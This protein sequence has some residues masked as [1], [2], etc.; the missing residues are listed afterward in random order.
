MTL[1]YDMASALRGASRPREGFNPPFGV[2]KTSEPLSCPIQRTT[3]SW[4][5]FIMSTPRPRKRLPVNPS[6]EHLKKQAKR[7]AARQ[8]SMQLADAQHQLAREYGCKNWAELAQ[9]VETM[10]RG[11]TEKI[12]VKKGLE[13]LPDA[14]NR[15]DI[16]EVRR[17]LTDGQF[18]QYDLDLALAR[19][20]LN[21]RQRHEIAE[22]LIEHGADPDGQYGGNYGPI[23][24]ATAE[25]LDPDG[26][27]FLIDHGADVTF[28]PIDTKY[29]PASP[30]IGVL[31]TYARGHNDRKHRYIDIL[32]ARNAYIPP[33]VTP[34]VMA[35]HRG[36]VETLRQMLDA[37]PSLLRRRVHRI[38]GQMN[39]PLDT[40]TLLHAAVEFGELE[41]I[42][43]LISR[44]AD[45]NARAQVMDGVGGHTPIYHAIASTGQGNLYVL[46]HL[47][48]RYGLRIDMNVRATIRHVDDFYF[49]NVTPL[50]YSEA[51]SGEDTP[52]WRRSSKR[53]LEIMRSLALRQAVRRNDV[54]EVG[55]LLDRGAD[56][57]RRADGGKTTL[58]LSVETGSVAMIELLQSHGALAWID[59]ES[60]RK[61]IDYVRDNAQLDPAMRQRLTGLL[62]VP[63]SGD[64]NFRAAIVA[65]D[66][67]DL[68][69]LKELLR[70]S[71]NLATM[72][73]GD[74]GSFAGG[75]FANPAL[76]WYV[77]EN[78]IR[79]DTLPANICDIA[80]VIIDAGATRDDITYTM[81]LVASG[82]VPRKCGLQIPLIQTLVRRGGDPG[83]ALTAAVQEHEQQAIEAL[84][85]FG[86]KP[87]LAA[88]AGLGRLDEL[89]E[90]LTRNEQQASATSPASSHK[91]SIQSAMSLAAQY[92]QTEAMKML[93]DHGVDPNVPLGLGTTPLHQAAWHDR[94]EMVELLLSRGANPTA[95]DARFDATPA[96][97]A[98]HNAH[99]ELADLLTSAEL[100]HR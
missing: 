17:I 47:I 100:S 11:A 2:V 53:E 19:A 40:A 69:T 79:N 94:R 60:G 3:G 36:D 35:I 24:L 49:R 91:T 8:P 38:P 82:C 32:L 63:R 50:E 59:D 42:D 58:H 14:A 4:K 84:L 73:S 98:R 34:E 6:I 39:P 55:A 65:I 76:L 12:S 22:L 62:D 81:A 23:V 85:R 99:P 72:H 88:A 5:G 86:A 30:M 92:G 67:G 83:G 77:A 7:I 26:L 96:Q 43:L 61:P 75:Y 37:D 45:I 74:S 1:G 31:S 78:P 64:P 13:P 25:C 28:A 21:F 89:R 95:R 97:W 29:G 16:D 10:G 68:T 27:Q 66:A 54:N 44:G 9:V 52:V 90:H 18:T 33:E 20:V 70:R 87:D 41:C 71:P 48:K 51:A 93:L 15:N 46:E 57:N 80:E 56:P